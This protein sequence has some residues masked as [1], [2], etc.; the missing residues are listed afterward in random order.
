MAELLNGVNGPVHGP[1]VQA[2]AVHG[3]VHVHPAPQ[4]SSPINQLP[5]AGPHFVGR[6]HA[7]DLLS[8]RV[9]RQATLLITSI[10]G[11]A[12]I[13][14]TTLA[15]HWARRERA[16]FPDGQLYV[17]LRGFDPAGPVDPATAVRGFLD[18]F[19]VPEERI[20][21]DLAAQVALYRSHVE[22]RRMLILLDNARDPDQVRPLL[23]GSPTCVVLVTSRNR[24][25]GLVAREQA[26]PLA[27][28]FLSVAESRELLSA[29]LGADRV[30]AER[31]A[32]DALAERCA[33]LPIALAIAGSR[34][35]TEPYLEVDELVT[36]LAEL[37][38]GDGL[39]VRAVFDS[40]YR[41]LSAEPARLFRLLGLHP[42]ADIGV[43]AAASLV[44]LPVRRTRRLL[45]ELTGAALLEVRSPGRY[46]Q[47]DLLR[48]YAAERAAEEETT[49]ARQTAIT[50]VLD[51]YLHTSFAG[52][53]QL[54]PYRDAIPLDPARAGVVL[55]E[56]PDL[57][58]AWDWFTAEHGNLLAAVDLAV[59]EGFTGHRWRL[60]WTLSSYFGRSGRWRDWEAT[61][62]EALTAAR[63]LG[64]R[65]VEA[66]ALRVLGRVHTL[67]GRYGDAVDVLDRAL[68]IP[69]GDAGRAHAHEA[70]SL[71]HER[72]GAM[73]DAHSHARTA[74][75]IADATG[76]RARR[77]NARIQLGRALVGLGRLDEARHRLGEVVDMTAGSGDRIGHA[78]AT[79]GLGRVRHRLGDFEG[80]VRRFGQ[81]LECYRDFGDRWSQAYALCRLGDSHAALGRHGDARRAWRES[82]ELF[83]RIGH[84]E[85]ESVRGRT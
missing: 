11:A 45:D 74:V 39:D 85:A 83:T 84:P 19:Q 59:R 72:R 22:G 10:V 78:D 5:P 41:T 44:G 49:E 56:V 70:I 34:A 37:S 57:A 7:L 12:G 68:A 4:P 18:A 38:T 25:G 73:D 80:A 52:E 62:L 28:D 81:A 51:C 58:A 33:R 82:W 48:E 13:G 26:T 14:K 20:P 65:E 69:V 43:P 9:D 40:S 2:G 36:E 23:P 16:R 24:L 60:P 42:G 61:Q 6:E 67:S 30:R 3:G 47:H 21:V 32:V 50:R 15:V 76:H 55:P 64:D 17:D 71:A 8:A 79:E 29:Y 63:A 31:E 75:A 53:R 46:R 35:A 77:V 27:L 1:V 66:L 54:Y